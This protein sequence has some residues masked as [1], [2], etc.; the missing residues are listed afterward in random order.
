MGSPFRS[1]GEGNSPDANGD[2]WDGRLSWLRRVVPITSVLP[3]FSFAS[4]TVLIGF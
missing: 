3:D 4:K 2:F 1:L